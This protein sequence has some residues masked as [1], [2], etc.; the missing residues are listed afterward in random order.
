MQEPHV[1]TT[2]SAFAEVAREAP[3]AARV[4]VEVRVRVDDPFLAYRR[5]RGRDRSRTRRERIERTDSVYLETTGG[6]AGWGYFATDPVFRLQ[7][8]DTL[9]PVGDAD[10]SP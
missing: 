1:V 6:Q 4:P 5:A 10:P 2:K 8:G 9:Q 3:G 7:V